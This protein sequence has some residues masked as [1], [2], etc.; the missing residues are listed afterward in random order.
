M[1]PLVRFLVALREALFPHKCPACGRFFHPEAVGKP[2]AAPSALSENAFAHIMAPVL[3]SRCRTQF[4][5]IESPKCS[6]C[7][8]MFTSRAGDDHVCAACLAQEPRFN[9]IRS[10]GQYDG[11]LMRLI[12]A[13]KYNRKIELARPLGRLLFHTFCSYTELCIPDV[14]VPVPLHMSRLRWRGFNQAALIIGR[15]PKFFRQ[16]G[17]LVPEIA[18]D[19]RLLRR[20]KK[21][22]SQ[23]GLDRAHRRLNI[24][25]AFTLAPDCRIE[26]KTILLVDDVCT[27]GATVDECAGI[28]KNGGADCVNVLTLARAT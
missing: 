26:G 24:R 5:P 15:W 22:P 12:H 20:I 4:Y 13:F 14:I 27:T 11:P 6:R 2:P 28:L 9:Y 10:A 1:K 3:C 21:T 8:E 19:G 7:G 16:S 17:Y 18:G 23:T 25:K